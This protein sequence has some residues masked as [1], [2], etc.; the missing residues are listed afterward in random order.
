MLLAVR[1]IHCLGAVLPKLRDHGAQSTNQI[2]RNIIIS[3]QHVFSWCSLW[4]GRPSA[5]DVLGWAPPVA[6]DPRQDP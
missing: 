3:N 1:S 6:T 2:Q 5:D 4:G